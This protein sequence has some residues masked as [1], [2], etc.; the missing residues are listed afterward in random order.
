MKLKESAEAQV[1]N[2]IAPAIIALDKLA[3]KEKAPVQFIRVAVRDFKKAAGLLDEI[4][5]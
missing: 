2:K 4:K 3:K 5:D 1:R